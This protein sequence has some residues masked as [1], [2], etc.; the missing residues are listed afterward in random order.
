MT[1]N[2]AFLT[3]QQ[4]AAPAGTGSIEISIV[5]D[6]SIYDGRFCNNGW[7]QELPNP[8]TKITWENVALISPATAAKLGINQGVVNNSLQVACLISSIMPNALYNLAINWLCCGKLANGTIAEASGILG[9]SPGPL[10]MLKQLA[11]TKFSYCLTPFADR[12]DESSRT[13][14][15]SRE[16]IRQIEAR[17]IRKL[18][19]ALR[20][21]HWD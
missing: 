20:E 3:Q 7:L 5:P 18:R 13:M 6:P 2:A 9:L 11:I 12:W 1:A 15:I 10:S 17:A 14:R 8:I 4:P 16:G 19:H 21:S